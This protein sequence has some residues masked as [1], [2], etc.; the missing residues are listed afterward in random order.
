MNHAFLCYF[1]QGHITAEI[2]GD[3]DL[4]LALNPKSKQSPHPRENYWESPWWVRA[5]PSCSPNE[6]QAE[7]SDVFLKTSCTSGQTPE[8]QWL[9]G[10]LMCKRPRAQTSWG[11]CAQWRIRGS[12]RILT[13]GKMMVSHVKADGDI[14]SHFHPKSLQS[15][16]YTPKHRQPPWSCHGGTKVS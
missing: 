12:R 9:H 6:V 16:Y 7:R 10:V 8:K 5:R 14:E 15:Q 11:L 1:L 2:K 4:F 3:S 13:G